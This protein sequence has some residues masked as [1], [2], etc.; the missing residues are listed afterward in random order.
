MK[1]GVNLL[2][3]EPYAAVIR[4]PEGATESRVAIIAEH[5]GAGRVSGFKVIGDESSPHDIGLRMVGSNLEVGQLEISGARVAGIEIDGEC[6]ATIS[7]NLIR[8]NSGIGVIIRGEAKP[9]LINNWITG[10]GRGADAV[11]RGGAVKPGVDIHSPARPLLIGNVIAEN[12]AEGIV[13]L[14]AESLE[15]VERRNY[16]GGDMK[17]NGRGKV[18]TAISESE[19][20][21]TGGTASGGGRALTTRRRR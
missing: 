9:Q 3:R 7:A 17:A 20:G 15:D 8:E 19:A 21:K 12:G 16:F 13:G 11:G 5:I 18:R 2:S 1:E 10:N 6:D 4:L 14:M